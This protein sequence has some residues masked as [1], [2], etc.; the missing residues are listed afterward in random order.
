[1]EVRLD[2]LYI[3]DWAPITIPSRVPLA[4]VFKNGDAVE[5]GDTVERYGTRLSQLLVHPGC[6]P[7]RNGLF[8]LMKLKVPLV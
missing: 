6:H 4:A 3:T 8:L 2:L 1:M 5:N 7:V